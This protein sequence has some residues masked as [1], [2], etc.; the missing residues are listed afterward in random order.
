M[1]SDEPRLPRRPCYDPFEVRRRMFNEAIEQCFG[2][3]R[4]PGKLRFLDPVKRRRRQFARRRV[5]I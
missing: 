4:E 3:S 1:M 2:R 5:A